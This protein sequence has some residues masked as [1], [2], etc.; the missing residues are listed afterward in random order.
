MHTHNTTELWL[1]HILIANGDPMCWLKSDEG[2]ISKN[3]IKHIHKKK[4]GMYNQKQLSDDHNPPGCI[5]ESTKDKESEVQ[6]NATI[7]S[8][9]SKNRCPACES[10]RGA[11]NITWNKWPC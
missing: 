7:I 10:K 6:P 1:N 4:H 9:N 2:A 8:W 5:G 11:I 3:L